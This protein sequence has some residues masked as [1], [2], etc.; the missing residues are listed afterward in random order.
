MQKALSF[1][2]LAVFL[3]QR[4]LLIGGSSMRLND[5]GIAGITLDKE[6]IIVRSKEV[7]RQEGN[8]SFFP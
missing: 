4:G 6:M 7:Q 1:V 3:I 5:S 8:F 2:L